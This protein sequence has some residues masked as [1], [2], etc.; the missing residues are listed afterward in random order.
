[1][2]NLRLST[3]KL[4]A[5]IAFF[6]GIALLAGCAVRWRER[7]PATGPRVDLNRYAMANANRD[8]VVLYM[9]RQDN[10]TCCAQTWLY[11]TSSNAWLNLE[12]P[13]HPTDGSE[14]F[15]LAHLDRDEVMLFA[16]DIGE[17][18]IYNIADNEWRKI[19]TDEQPSPRTQR[20]MAYLRPGK[21]LLYG[22]RPNQTTD[23]LDDTWIFQPKLESKDGYQWRNITE[24]VELNEVGRQRHAMANAGLDR[25]VMFGGIDDDGAATDSTYLFENGTW[26]QVEPATGPPAARYD[27]SMAYAGADR[28]ILF[29]GRNVNDN[30]LGDSWLFG[31][32]SSIWS[33]YQSPSVPSQRAESV[34]AGSLEEEQCVF[35][36]TVVL[37]SGRNNSALLYDTWT[38]GALE[39]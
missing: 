24:E 22:G 19:Q 23:A 29:G 17:T 12:P 28:M 37:Y 35:P 20:A 7:N 18:W 14:G 4:A 1:M 3:R 32:F 6:V 30:L 15:A 5:G 25:V 11:N 38:Y 34:M 36:V 26:I 9:S 21:V 16:G 2:G 13:S 31:V 27:H 33:L 8:R 39:C 10:G